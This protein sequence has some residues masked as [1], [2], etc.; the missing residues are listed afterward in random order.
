MM[1]TDPE[2]IDPEMICGLNLLQEVASRLA[3]DTSMPVL[4][5]RK[6][7]AKLSMPISMTPL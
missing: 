1:L 2:Y 6:I 3:D 7:A 4:G 5:S